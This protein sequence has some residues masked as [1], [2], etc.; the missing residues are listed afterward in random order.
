[1]A[2]VLA[3]VVG[4]GWGGT[5]L[6]GSIQQ[7][8][9]HLP[10]VG[11]DNNNGAGGQA[12]TGG[13]LQ[14]AGSA[15]DLA[16][17][18]ARAVTAGDNLVFYSV[19]GDGKTVVHAVDPANG[20]EK[21]K[22]DVGVDPA[23]ASMHTVGDLLVLDAKKSATDG[24]KDM[25]VV[26]QAGDGHRVQKLDWSRRADVA[27]LG[28][29]AIVATNWQPFQ[30]LRVNLKTGQTSWKSTPLAS[31]IAYHPVAPELTWT[32]GP[33]NVPA[34]DDGFSESFG[35]NPDR[36]VQLDAD[37]NTVQVVNGSGKVTTH[38]TVP[39]RD[40]LLTVVWTAF[41]GLVIGALNDDASPGR[42]ALGAYRLDNLKQAWNPVGVG[43]GDEIKYVHPCGEHLVCATYNKKS[44]DTNAVIA[45]DTRTGQKVTWTS[46]PPYGEFSDDPYWSVYAR[47]MVYG[48]GGFPP[49]LGCSGTGLRVLNPGTGATVRTLAGD[50]RCSATLVAGAGRYLA[51]RTVHVNLTSSSTAWQVSLLDLTTGKQTDALDTHNKE[52]PVAV[53]VSGT[54]LAVLG[55]DRKLQIAVA[56]KLT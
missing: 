54:T 52:L 46:Q 40:E 5:K 30:T 55:G 47:S 56:A 10:V 39:I 6:F 3:V 13:P 26:L 41:D 42:A 4:V 33:A 50:Q 37:A 48:D 14:L 7:G 51:V 31:I 29:D 44:D 43:A 18:G 24:G 36:F 23:E 25:R 49:Q 20:K 8:L 15:I 34:P 28:T 12:G 9:S 21:W 27:Y 53:A 45:V 11:G 19:S 32:A 2:I 22:Q 1:V 16:G 35:V 17:D 38:G